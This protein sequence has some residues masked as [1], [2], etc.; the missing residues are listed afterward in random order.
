MSHPTP[1]SPLTHRVASQASI[2]RML[3]EMSAC[4]FTTGTLTL[5]AGALTRS[6]FH[7]PVA[8]FQGFSRHGSCAVPKRW[9]RRH[10]G[11]VRPRATQ[12]AYWPAV[13][14]ANLT[15]QLICSFGG[16]W[17]VEPAT[18]FKMDYGWILHL[19]L[20]SFPFLSSFCFS[21]SC[22]PTPSVSPPPPPP[23]PHTHCRHSISG[24]CSRTAAVQPSSS[25]NC[26]FTGEPER[27][28]P[29]SF[30]HI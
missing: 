3:W 29:F 17:G 20:H 23:P 4:S 24:W 19:R 10:C 28:V 14:S 15:F 22:W 30:T 16:W 6:P 12:P 9:T 5:R 13:R 18:R 7:I 1:H 21:Y 8:L 27:M 25:S 26:L 11:R 2:S